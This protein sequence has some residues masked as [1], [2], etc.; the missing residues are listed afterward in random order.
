MP[1]RSALT[2]APCWIDL[3]TSDTAAAERFYGALFGWAAE[4]ADE[5]KYGGYIT[6]SQGDRA[7][8]GAMRNDGTGGQPDTWTVYL[9][10][11]DIA[12]TARS[13]AEH[14]GAVFMGPMEVPDTG[15]MAVV[16]DPGGAAVG[17]WQAGQFG[18]FDVISENG[19]PGWFELHT[20]SYADATRFYADVFGWETH[21]MSD[22]P[23]FRYTTLGGGDA[24][25]AG[26]MDGSVVEDPDAPMGWQV[27]FAVDSADDTVARAVELGASVVDQPEDTPYGRLA[28]LADPTGARFKLVQGPAS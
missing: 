4:H 8:A 3:F 19:T 20:R 25:A 11:N 10:S 7:V 9:A 1:A 24:Q 5:E 21:T 16:G 27:Y 28:T 14:G 18:G 23:Q 26:I 13:A 12:A 22:T 15:Q 17:I 6:F 2:G